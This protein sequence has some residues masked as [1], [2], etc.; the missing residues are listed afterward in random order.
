[1]LQMRFFALL[2]LVV[3]GGVS[4]A[5]ADSDIF[6][7]LA[8]KA[9]T[10]GLGL[11]NSGYMIAG[12]GLVVFSVMAIFNKISWKNLAY[13]MLS[14]FLLSIMFAAVNYV[15]EGGKSIPELKYDSSGSEAG[16]VP[17]DATKVQVNKS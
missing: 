4:D 1:M 2:F 13:I 16:S 6:V 10:I 9:T 17:G 8:D 14:C 5:F 7:Q 3:C 15:A 12:M 11:R